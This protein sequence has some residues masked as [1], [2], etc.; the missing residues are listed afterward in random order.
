M[1]ALFIVL[2]H[3][4]GRRDVMWKRLIGVDGRKRMKMKRWSKISQALVCFEHADSDQLAPQR[5]ILS[6]VFERFGVDSRKH[7]K[8]LVWTQI[9]RCVFDDN[10]NAKF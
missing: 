10:E 4:Y 6:G 2:E 9:D 3:Q 7:T 5:A 8:T 1:A